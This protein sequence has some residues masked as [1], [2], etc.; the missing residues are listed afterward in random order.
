MRPQSD[1]DGRLKVQRIT[2]VYGSQ[3]VM[4]RKLAILLCV[5]WVVGLGLCVKEMEENKHF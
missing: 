2:S 3:V 1:T 5:K 4:D